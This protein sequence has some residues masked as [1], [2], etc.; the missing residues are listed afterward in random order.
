M[1]IKN[2]FELRTLC[3][4]HVIIASGRENID[5]SK[6]VNLNES[7]AIMWNAVIGKDFDAEDMA[8]ALM[9]E[10]EVDEATALADAKR[11]ADEWVELG[12]ATA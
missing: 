2:G 5:F 9:A 6:V 4:E 12:M 1:K 3:G 10:Y 7:A 11:I 8:K